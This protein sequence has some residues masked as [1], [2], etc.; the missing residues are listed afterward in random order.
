[1]SGRAAFF[2]ALVADP[3]LS[4]MNINDETVFHN[5]SNEERPTNAT[6]FVILRWGVQGRPPFG[7]DSPK[8]SEQVTVWV[9]WPREVTNDFEKLEK[10]LDAIDDVCREMRDLPGN[11]NYT[12]SFVDIGGRS[13]D[14]TDDGFNTITKNGTYEVFSRRS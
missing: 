5:W 13:P 10:V 2:D 3:I 11:D 7:W 12:L 1:M 8:A 14:L 4:A 6:P 9:H